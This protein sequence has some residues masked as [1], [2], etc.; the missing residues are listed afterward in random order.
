[1]DSPGKS[2]RASFTINAAE[3]TGR[4]FDPFRP[5]DQHWRR[6]RRPAHF[7]KNN[8]WANGLLLLLFNNTAFANVGNTGGLQPSSVAGSLYLSLHTSDP[9]A[10]GNQSSNEIAYTSYAR[11]AVARSSAGWTVSG[12]TVDLAALTS[13]PIGT[14]GS[15]T[16][17][18]AGIGTAAT[19]NGVLLYSG[20]LSNPSTIV[21]GLNIT[22]QLTSA[23]GV[24]ES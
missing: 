19:G 21:T 13:F 2:S 1:M 9:T 18:Y 8:S 12:D 23:A 15:G 7:A 4:Q 5:Q 20:A 11:V 14:G 6:R 17:A 16:A 10:S 22:P 24:T 3:I